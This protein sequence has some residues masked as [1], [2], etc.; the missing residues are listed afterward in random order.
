M[1]EMGRILYEKL[2]TVVLGLNG[3]RE[4][5]DGLFV[6]ITNPY[7]L[8][9]MLYPWLFT[10]DGDLVR[11]IYRNL[12]LEIP[13]YHPDNIPI[14]IPEGSIDYARRGSFT[15]DFFKSHGN[16]QNPYHD[17]A[18]V[19]LLNSDFN[20]TSVLA[21]VLFHLAPKNL[22]RTNGSKGGRFDAALRVSGEPGII[23]CGI[24]G[25][26]QQEHTIHIFE[27]G[28]ETTSLYQK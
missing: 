4:Y 2:T 5:Y 9:S 13:S 14:S 8:H 15:E 27:G 11:E 17:G 6:V 21:G 7:G 19:Y 3:L 12:G 28:K 23:C 26:N 22:I 24:I 18:L 16:R 20:P 25:N 10:S 1:S